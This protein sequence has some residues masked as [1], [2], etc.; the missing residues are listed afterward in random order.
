MPIINYEQVDKLNAFKKHADIFGVESKRALVVER[1]DSRNTGIILTSIVKISVP[2]E[3]QIF[4]NN[5]ET[6]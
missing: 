1:S 3:I 4:T 2:M 6:A 5:Y